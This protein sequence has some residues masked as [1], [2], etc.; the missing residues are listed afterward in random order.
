MRALPEVLSDKNFLECLL[1]ADLGLKRTQEFVL[2]ICIPVII[3]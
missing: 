1:N 2:L 3:G